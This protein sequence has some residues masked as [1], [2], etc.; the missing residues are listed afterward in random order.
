M[1]T[2]FEAAQKAQDVFHRNVDTLVAGFLIRNPHIDPGDVEMIF[3]PGPGGVLRFTI[4]AKELH[5]PTAIQSGEASQEYMEGWNACRQ[6]MI[7]TVYHRSES[8]M[9]TPLTLETDNG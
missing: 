4:E 8:S 1:S 2:I 9:S 5:V 6:A 3:Q 7:D